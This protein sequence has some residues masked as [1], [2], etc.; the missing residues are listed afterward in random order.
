M[1]CF[2]RAGRDTDAAGFIALIGA[3]W[4]EY[5]GCVLDVDG[6]VP[7]LRALASYFSDKGGALWA[8]EAGDAIAGMIGVAPG[9][10]G[11]EIS[12]MYVAREQRGS[13]L[14][15][16]LLERAEVHALRHGATRLH[17]WTDTR[18]E[19]A[20]SFYA[21]QGY[22]RAG[23]IR[24]LDDLSNSLEFRFV[25]PVDGVEI[26]DAA[27]A[28]SAERRLAEILI[29][30]VGAGSSV[31]YLPPLAPEVARGFYREVA[32]DVAAGRKILLAGWVEAKLAGTVLLDIIP[33]PNQPHRAEVQK[34]LVH[35]DAR[36]R[37]LARLLMHHAEQA[38]R[39]AGRNLLTLDTEAGSNA[40]ALYRGLGWT[41][42]GRIPGY[43]LNA[44]GRLIDTLIF[45]KNLPGKGAA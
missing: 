9:A 8:A 5:P 40:A 42:A 13:G 4:A 19:R 41:E 24:V 37:G 34:L 16:E 21:R 18:F 25:K 39:D 33:K 32:R 20:H 22:V 3:C 17:L 2:I 10:G 43:A 14:A 27:A 45:Y 36:R 15:R 29:A 38:A 28:V 11:W 30:C 1:G 31:G 35:P 23:A 12:R 6:E 44:E 7:E 26:L